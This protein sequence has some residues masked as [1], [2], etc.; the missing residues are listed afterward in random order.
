M[1]TSRPVPRVPTRKTDQKGYLFV[2]RN[3]KVYKKCQDVLANL[4]YMQYDEPVIGWKHFH[5]GSTKKQNNP[6]NLFQGG[7]HNES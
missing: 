5:N 3:A 2:V 6:S 4:E 7:K 1:E